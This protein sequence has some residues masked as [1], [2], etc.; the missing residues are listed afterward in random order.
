VFKKP[1]LAVT[2]EDAATLKY[3]VLATV[4]LDGIR[5]LVVD[6]KAVSR[7]FLPIPNRFIRAQ[8]E[9]NC[10]NGFDGEIM[11]PG[12]DFNTVQSLVMREEGEPGFEYH[13]FD[14][15]ERGIDRPYE[16]RMADLQTLEEHM[17]AP[18]VRMVLPVRVESI[19]ELNAFEEKALADGH[20]GV[21][22]RSP[23][24]PYKNGR[25]TL[26]EGYLLKIKRFADSEA[27]VIGFEEKLTN[28]NEKTRDELG[29]AKRSSHKVNLVPA[30]TLGTLLMKIEAT[31]VEFGIGT[32]FDAATRQEIWDN[33]HK[34]LGAFVTFSHQPSGAKSLEEGGK[35]RFPVFKGFR[36]A[37]DM[38]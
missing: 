26:K 35:P 4:K 12:A 1:M 6:G 30:G 8:I 21:M 20:E 23:D 34:Y 25:S 37:E 29:N 3:P 14:Y 15:V 19:K 7:K 22:V 38:S 16:V 33:R 32:G 13:V 11:I 27:V 2:C 10:P 31:G 36:S 28:T 17:I 24:G 18:F 5:C 9:Q